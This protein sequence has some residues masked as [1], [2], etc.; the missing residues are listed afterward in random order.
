VVAVARRPVVG[1]DLQRLLVGGG[2]ELVVARVEVRLA[3]QRPGGAA[4]RRALR[5]LLQVGDRRV[6]EALLQRD[7]T[8]ADQRRDVA[9][10]AL[11]RS[12]LLPGPPLISTTSSTTTTITTPTPIATILP[13]GRPG[14]W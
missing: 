14:C 3:E 7:L 13:I 2:R 5:R 4:L 10:V 12:S 6:V 8:E 9:G 11:A 1:I